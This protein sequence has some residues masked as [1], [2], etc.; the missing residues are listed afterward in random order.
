MVSVEKFVV[1]TAVIKY[2]LEEK[3]YHLSFFKFFKQEE[4]TRL[5]NRPLEL[6]KYF[7]ESRLITVNRRTP[8]GKI[9]K[10]WRYQPWLNQ[11]AFIVVLHSVFQNQRSRFRERTPFRSLS[12]SFVPL[13]PPVGG[14]KSFIMETRC[15]SHCCVGGLA[16]IQSPSVRQHRGDA[17][18]FYFPKILP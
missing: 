5:R 15:S 4:R 13:P 18:L 3:S 10:P 14:E 2:R 6:G 7:E 12:P 8:H 16:P 9:K 17:V 11:L 1:G